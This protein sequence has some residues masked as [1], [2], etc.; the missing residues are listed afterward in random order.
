M[1]QT[2][3]D[4]IYAMGYSDEER[5]RLIDQAALYRSS[6]SRLLSDAGIAPGARV[7]DVGCGVGDVSLLAASIVGP[8]GAVVGVDGDRRSLAVAED[9]AR[10]AGLR[11]VTF[12][13]G[14]L[15]ELAFEE[16]FD[17]VVGRFVLMYLADPA[18]AVRRLA[19]HVRPGGAVAFQ[20]MHINVATRSWGLSPSSLYER[21]VEWIL[22]TLAGA[23]VD[24]EMGL[25]L[26]ATLSQ[27]GLPTPTAT[28]YCPVLSGPDHPGYQLFADIL[29]SILPLM[30]AFGVATA[31]A[32]DL[33][34]YAERLAAEV[35]ANQAMACCAPAVAAWT[36]KPPAGGADQR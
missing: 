8:G 33:D 17:A 36:M 35:A 18:D 34:T 26:A 1:T 2:T 20:E 10:Q 9:R 7:L 11:N 22:K 23:G 27:A 3:D 5:R 30:E 14:D 6:T 15:R 32:V 4:P 28:L 12:R 19:G 25:K 24:S 31:A 21:T 29:R 13:E 16:P